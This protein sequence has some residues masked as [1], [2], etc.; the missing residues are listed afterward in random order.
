MQTFVIGG[1]EHTELIHLY[2]RTWRNE[3]AVEIPL[4]LAFLDQ[5][6]GRVLE[7]GN[8]LANYR[9]SEHLVID[10]YERSPGVINADVVD[11]QTPERFEAI[12]SV[13]TLEHVGWDE[14]VR[15]PRKIVRAIANLRS[16]L[17]PYGRMLVTCT[18]SYNPYLDALIAGNDLDSVREIF[19]VRANG[20]WTESDRATAVAQGVRPSGCSALWVAEFTAL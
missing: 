4:A 12:V 17:M 11:Y 6:P 3:R 10:K 19:L 13:S 7:V 8:V 20:K 15:D 1:V 9:R 2:N 16:L 5:H 18:L 14:D